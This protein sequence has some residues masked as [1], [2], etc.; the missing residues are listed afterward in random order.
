MTPASC[1]PMIVMSERLENMQDEKIV[2]ADISLVLNKLAG[3]D[4]FTEY[5]TNA[6][7]QAAS[8]LERMR[9]VI[10]ATWKSSGSPLSDGEAHSLVNHFSH[11]P[12]LFELRTR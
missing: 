4:V 9:E 10:A 12:W 6:C 5:T 8:L 7:T 2:V 11:A 1:G 3:S